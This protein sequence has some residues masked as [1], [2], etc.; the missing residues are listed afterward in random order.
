VL[1]PDPSF[2]VYRIAALGHGLDPIEV[3]LDDDMQL[4]FELVDD[5]MTGAAPNLAFFAL[6][7]NPT[8]TLWAPERVAELAAQATQTT[9][10]SPTRRTSTT[11]A[12]RCCRGCPSC[13]TWSSCARCRRSAWPACGSA[14]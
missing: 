1:Y 5:A 9:I 2:V 11:A 3:P 6:P 14:S 4:D 13:R 12:A 7:N 8:G 10:V